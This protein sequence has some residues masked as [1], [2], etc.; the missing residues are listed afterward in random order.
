MKTL[1]I[2]GNR[3]VGAE[4]LWHLLR[5]G[6]ALTVLSLDPPPDEARPH[7]RWLRVNRND[8]EALGPLFA[9]ESF[10][11]VVDNIAYEPRQ[12]ERLMAALNGR[13]G[14]Y[15]LTSTTD[16]YPSHFPRGYTEDQVDIR[17]YDLT[18][19]TPSARYNYGKRS[20]E[21]V[22]QR[23]GLPWTVLRPC[24]VSGPRDNLNGAPASRTIHWFE[25]SGR[26]HFWVSR[27]LDGGPILLSSR[28]E[29]VFKLL[30]V[31][32]LARAVTHVMGLPE[33]SNQAYNVTGDEFWTNER[34]VRALA[35]A[36]GTDPDMVH[37]PQ[38]VLEQAGIDY[39]PVYGTGA[40]WTL[41][42]NAKL[43]TT[44][45]K[46]TP[47]E[48]WLPLLLEANARP[49]LRTWYHTRIPEI[50][51]A[52]HLQRLR[53]HRATLAPAITGV[54][55]PPPP[56][57][58]VATDALPIP[59]RME[60]GASNRWKGRILRQKGGA[61]P[62]EGFFN[63]LGEGTIS[64]IGIGTW[65]GDLSSETDQRYMGTLMH[66]ASRGINVFDTAINY[67][68]MKAERCVGTAVRQLVALGFSRG[69]LYIASKGGYI[70]HD[71]GDNRN[72]ESYLRESY[73]APGLIEADELDR[74]HSI[75]PRF[76]AHQIDQSLANLGLATIDLYY[77]HNPEDEIPHLG[78]E[79]FYARLL[80]TFVILEQAVMA[81]KIA[82]YGLA[83]WNGLRV[84]AEDPRHLS[85]E[86]VV[87]TAREAAARLQIPKHHLGA[88]QM[89]FNMRDHHPLTRPTQSLDNRRVPALE[90][91]AALGLYAFTSASVL[92]GAAV[93]E[94]IR[95]ISSG[96][97]ER[98]AAL[99]GAYSTP[100]VGTAL[101]GMRRTSSVEEALVVGSLPVMPR[102]QLMNMLGES[103]QQAG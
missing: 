63:P 4:I 3:F 9:G 91:I 8:E 73:L 44:G 67:R 93:P 79:G 70:T 71:A 24:M 23:S 41:P 16:L 11:C 69:T 66:A 64:R 81:G 35:A 33:A 31:N 15:L 50:A 29:V 92:Q 42:D 38:A 61:V 77:L 68:N 65:M 40:A 95:L 12:V 32:D 59:G 87:A 27:V 6:H 10:D 100:G 2:G 19:L 98:T 30:L 20:C 18:G 103:T 94:Q 86:R 74:R 84:G 72:A 55:I 45:W 22:L 1:L 88:I 80:E 57:P 13:V 62:L 52:R 14:R 85:L 99:R 101:V 17:D 47:A 83:T 39:S 90:A 97:T 75:Q 60:K 34:L 89:P 58:L 36:A 28:D 78:Q 51:L 96:L 54:T 21:A 37:V 46:P 26:S 43:K 48:Q 49:H 76:I 53:Q 102:E 82:R 5:A 25:E 56:I 7:L